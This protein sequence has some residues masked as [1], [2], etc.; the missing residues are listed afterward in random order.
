MGY[1]DAKL[2]CEYMLD[3]TLHHYPDDFRTMAVRVGQIAGSKT[4]GY[5]NPV[6]HLAHL[7]KSSQ[8]LKVL[9]DLDG[10]R[11]IFEFFKSDSGHVDF[12]T[13]NVLVP[14]Q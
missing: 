14:R 5:W 2:I 13:G 12:L 8:T 4:N 1:A 9:P 11:F 6:E 10:V 7:I 3:E